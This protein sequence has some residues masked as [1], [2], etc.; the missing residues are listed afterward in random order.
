MQ[1]FPYRKGSQGRIQGVAQSLVG[2]KFEKISIEAAGMDEG[3]ENIVALPPD[4]GDNR[5]VDSYVEDILAV[6]GDNDG[7]DVGHEA[8]GEF[9]LDYDRDES[10]SSEDDDLIDVRT[11][12]KCLRTARAS[13]CSISRRWRRMS[14]FDT[15]LPTGRNDEVLANHDPDLLSKWWL[16]GGST[17]TWTRSHFPTLIFVEVSPF[18][19]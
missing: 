10:A 15:V 7:C 16:P 14:S 11:G 4:K 3:V 1:R 13:A 19:C 8:A 2:R 12:A 9:E 18:A 6:G 17:A 5:D